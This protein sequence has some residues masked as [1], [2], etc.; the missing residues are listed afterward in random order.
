MATKTS[1]IFT[2]QMTLVDWLIIWIIK[3]LLAPYFYVLN[4][5]L[6][7][8]TLQRVLFIYLLEAKQACPLKE[9]KVKFQ[10]GRQLRTQ[11]LLT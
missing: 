10:S 11:K 6:S 9:A 8:V 7:A 5:T 2:I 4:N 3:N 1:L